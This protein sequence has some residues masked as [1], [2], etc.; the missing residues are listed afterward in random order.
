[1]T[2]TISEEIKQYWEAKSLTPLDD[3]GLRPTGRDSYLQQAL[4]TAILKHL[5]AG[6]SILDVGCG[7][8]ASSVIFAKGSQAKSLVGID[9][10]ENYIKQAKELGAREGLVNA[11]FMHGDVLDLAKTVKPYLPVDVAIT[12][13][14]LINLPEESQQFKA[15]DNII[16]CL[17]KGGLY[18]CSEGW[19]ESWAA[20][21]RL[22]ERCGLDKMYLVPHNKL[23]NKERFIEHLA[24]KA[25]LVA[26]ESLGFYVF[27]S[28]VLQPLVTAP[29][30]PRHLHEINKVAA[31]LYALGIVAAEFDEIGYPGV[32]VFRKKV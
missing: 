27:L 30:P 19:E 12:I 17:P 1:M 28:R 4:E 32:C 22:R 31:Q 8:G 11:Q 3:M 29:Q 20:L 10:V 21:D 23:V 15:V 16:D 5:P 13:R 26:Y 14:C 9:Y 2:A 25:E 24:P 6:K 7:D 18:I